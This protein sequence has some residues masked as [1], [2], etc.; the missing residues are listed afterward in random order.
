MKCQD[1]MIS[2]RDQKRIDV[3]KNGF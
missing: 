2:Y 1:V 3:T